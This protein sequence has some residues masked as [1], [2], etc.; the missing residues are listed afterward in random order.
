MNNRVGDQMMKEEQVRELQQKQILDFVR[1][2][3][4]DALTSRVSTSPYFLVK[5]DLPIIAGYS[6]Y[7]DA[8]F[9]R[10]SLDSICMYV[11]AILVLDGRYLDFKEMEP[12]A[13]YEILSDVAS[14]FDPRW[15]AG[16]I[17]NQK[18]VYCSTDIAYGPMLEVEKRDLMFQAARPHGFLFIID[19]DEVCVGDVKAGL[20]FVRANPDTKIFWVKVEEE[21]NPGWKP[22]IIKL[23]AGLH[24]GA[25]H[26]TI[27]DR[28]NELVTDSVYR[29]EYSD[30]SDHK[31]IAC[32]KI[33]NFGSKRSGERGMQRIAYRKIL[34]AKTWEERA[35]P[36]LRSAI[37]ENIDTEMEAG[38]L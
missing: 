11:S 27:L 38:V 31:Q 30:S 29:E 22:R 13:S 15:F 17:I 8:E 23:E 33:C 7:R 21:G 3:L 2:F 37:V 6:I 26:W 24:Y 5:T 34:A 35:P 36:P 18:V 16:E 32:F 9:F 20:D 10:S 28:K 19:G 4:D 25:N 1:S 12:D 14:R